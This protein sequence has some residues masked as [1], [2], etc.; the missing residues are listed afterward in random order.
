MKTTQIITVIFFVF[1]IFGYLITEPAYSP[2]PKALPRIPFFL[3][4]LF[5]LTS[6]AIISAKRYKYFYR[7]VKVIGIVE[8]WEVA[9]GKAGRY[10]YPIVH[11]TAPDGKN[12]RVKNCHSVTTQSPKGKP[13]TYPVY[14][15]SNA[16]SQGLMYQKFGFWWP[17][18]MSLILAVVFLYASF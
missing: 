1:L 4:G 13:S 18:I 9:Q 12:Y 8:R 16:P 5:C 11:F 14:Y 3:L 6:S 7:G 15:L 2:Q 17:G 10:Y